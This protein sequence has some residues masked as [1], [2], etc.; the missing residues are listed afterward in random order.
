[1][2]KSKESVPGNT[3]K[4]KKRQKKIPEQKKKFPGTIKSFPGTTRKH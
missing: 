2:Q 1:M 3:H 4:K